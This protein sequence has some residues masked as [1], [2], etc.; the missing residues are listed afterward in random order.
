LLAA[1]DLVQVGE[2]RAASLMLAERALLLR[3]AAVALGDPRLERGASR[4]DRLR[5]VVVGSGNSNG[6]GEAWGSDLLLLS[7]LLTTSGRQLLQ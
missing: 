1:G 7:H 5:T 3:R 4:V 6:N 2:S